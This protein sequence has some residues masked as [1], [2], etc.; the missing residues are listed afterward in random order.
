MGCIQVLLRDNPL[1]K[2]GLTL[3]QWIDYFG[4]IFYFFFGLP[5]LICLVAPLASLLF[6]TPPLTADVLALTNYFFSFFLASALVMRPV[7]R[8]SRNPFWSDVYE[9]AMC[10]AL[11]VVA[12]KALAAPRRERLFEVTPKGQRVK[13]SSATEL[14]SAW[15]HLVTFGLLVIGLVVGVRHWGQGVGDPGLPVSL[16]WGSA[17]LL[18]LTVALFVA[19]EQAQGRQGFRLKRDF[20]GALFVDGEEVPARVVNVSEEGAAVTVEQPI[21][22][23]QE[24]TKFAL[25]SSLGVLV[26]LTARIVRQE[27]KPSGGI[28]VGL[29]FDEL[30]EHT[31]Q[32]LVDKLYGDPTPWED[33]YRIQPGIGSSLRSLFQ[34]LTVPWRPL[35]W[36]RRNMIRVTGG[37]MCLITAPSSVWRG[38][39]E[40]MSFTGVSALFSEFSQ[41]SLAGTLLELPGVTLKVSPVAIVRKGRKTLVHFQVVSIESG[42]KRWRQLHNARWRAA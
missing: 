31:R 22:T 14:S 40:D 18:L 24:S 36:N 37:T 12:L 1:T 17:N 26:T 38:R 11:S 15:P 29:Q 19:S 10:F 9:I 39:V 28:D 32:I 20:A 8:G 25:T 4:S 7:S 35:T 13:K 5:R 6:S 16:F 33:T 2:R 23:L 30:D 41:D 21:F 27:P 3:A 42:E 34:A